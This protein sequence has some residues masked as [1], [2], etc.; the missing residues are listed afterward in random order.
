MG[1]DP[2]SGKRQY[3]NKTIHGTRKDAQAYLNQSQVT[4]TSECSSKP[5]RMSLDQYLDKW[6]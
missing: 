3:R 5:S 6:L 4:G 2:V 1:R